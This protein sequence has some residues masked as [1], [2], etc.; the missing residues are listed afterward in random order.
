MCAGSSL[1]NDL[2][3]SKKLIND[4]TASSSGDEAGEK[5]QEIQAILARLEACDEQEAGD[6][7][8]LQEMWACTDVKSPTFV[9]DMEMTKA[10]LCSVEETAIARE[11]AAAELVAKTQ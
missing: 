7:A 10:L 6:I 9:E 1:I 8:M 2:T 11:K 5:M 3:R 4:F